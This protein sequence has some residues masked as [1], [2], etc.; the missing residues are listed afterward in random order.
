MA[1]SITT[2]RYFMFYILLTYYISISLHF[3]PS[4]NRKKERRKFYTERQQTTTLCLHCTLTCKLGPILLLSIK[5]KYHPIQLERGPSSL[6]FLVFGRQL[7]A[8]HDPFGRDLR[9]TGC[10]SNISA[11][12]SSS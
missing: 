9:E 11:Q 3:S 6:S 5:T 1:H 12:S 8:N 2:Q 10:F 7:Q 4:K